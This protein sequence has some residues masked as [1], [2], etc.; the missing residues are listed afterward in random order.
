MDPEKGTEQKDK[1]RKTFKINL[2]KQ[3]MRKTIDLNHLIKL[4][5]TS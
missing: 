1:N 3:F 2:W 4:N 5:N